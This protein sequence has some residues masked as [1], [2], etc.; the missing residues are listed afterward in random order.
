MKRMV[1]SVVTAVCVVGMAA[2]AA[3]QAP[4]IAVKL[5]PRMGLYVAVT[6]LG[7]ITEATRT[8]IA[9]KSGS[10]AL[11]LGA[12]LDL[13]VLP[14]GIRAN[15]D[16]KTGSN[17]ATRGLTQE[18]E[19]TMLALAADLV[20][21]PLPKLIL[22][23]PYLF[24]GGGVRQ[25]DF[26]TENIDVIEDASDPAVHVGGGLDLTLGPLALNAELGDYISWYEIQVGAD[27]EMQHDLFVTVG[28]V[29]ELL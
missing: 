10:L 22:I 4:G 23:Q 25:Y 16:Y 17:V 2:P 9:A 27:A 14:V 5:N 26:D 18:V 7:Q 19:P 28:I 6:D 29:F 12:E 13:A 15:V 1:R 21:R 20:F 3:A 24:A 8:I 11:G